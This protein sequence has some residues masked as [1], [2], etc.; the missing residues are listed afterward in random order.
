[1]GI[2]YGWTCVKE[3]QEITTGK[4]DE[5]YGQEANASYAA[6]FKTQEE[7]LDKAKKL[8]RQIGDNY[9]VYKLVATHFIK[10]PACEVQEAE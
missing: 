7:A 10:P 2:V 1:M 5:R 6:V 3:G 9:V 8:S 4:Y